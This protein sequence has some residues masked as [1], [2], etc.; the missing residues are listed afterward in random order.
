MTARPASTG[1]SSISLT[2]KG[3]W[4]TATAYVVGDVVTQ[5]SLRYV[6]KTAH[7]SGT[8]ATDLAAT[9]WTLLGAVSDTDTDT[10][11]S[12][13]R[14]GNWVT[15]TAYVFGDI[16][17]FNGAVYVCKTA[18]TSG[19][20]STDLAALKWTL[21]GVDPA[22][23]LEPWAGETAAIWGHSW[24]YGSGASGTGPTG[25]PYGYYNRLRDQR[26]FTT[27]R[28]LNAA[29]GGDMMLNQAGT[30]ASIGLP[31]TEPG[32]AIIGCVVNDVNQY[33]GGNA[34]KQ[35]KA[36]AGFTNG[37]TYIIEYLRAASRQTDAAVGTFT[38]TWSTIT[39]A[40]VATGMMSNQF[41]Q[42][43]TQNDT[44]DFFYT[45]GSSTLTSLDLILG[46]CDDLAATGAGVPLG[47]S[48]KVEVDGV[49][50]ATGS[51]SNQYLVTSNG[52]RYIGPVVV[53]LTGLAVGGGNRHIVITKTDATGTALRFNG[54]IVPQDTGAAP[55][56]TNPGIFMRPI[57]VM[58]D[59]PTAAGNPSTEYSAYQTFLTQINTVC[60]NYPTAEVIPVDI[61]AAGW[62]YSLHIP[63][64]SV[65]G[66]PNDRGHQFMADTLY[67]SL[68]TLTKTRGL[69]WQ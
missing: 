29:A 12:L 4:L 11:P 26:K 37:L 8:F 30:L 35:S 50:V 14:K 19:T 48:Y 3:A 58:S 18:H 10:N 36:L 51:L 67:N 33:I 63:N 42:T 49:Q 20:F 66:H 2:D 28:F 54:Y 46:G 64:A 69:S 68:R 57:A 39:T 23:A 5:N 44:V 21:T 24:A 53:K 52:P 45:V 1:T 40:G 59:G 47:A 6:C 7:T 32:V 41:H 17:T 38:G 65:S 60:A 9:K 16:V 55:Y 43:V 34:L 22:A 27:N 25:L 56:T 62:D 13:T 15:S 31:Y 61:M